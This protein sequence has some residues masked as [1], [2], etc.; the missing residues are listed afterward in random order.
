MKPQASKVWI[1]KPN[2]GKAPQGT[3]AT[4]SKVAVPKP[5]KNSGSASPAVKSVGKKKPPVVPVPQAPVAAVQ[6]PAG[7]I[8]PQPAA[9][10]VIP[11]Q[12]ITPKKEQWFKPHITTD[13]YNQQVISDKDARFV[14]WYKMIK[15]TLLPQQRIEMWWKLLMRLVQETPIEVTEKRKNIVIDLECNHTIVRNPVTSD[16][17]KA[18]LYRSAAEIV[19]LT[20]SLNKMKKHGLFTFIDYYGSRRITK[21]LQ[22][23]ITR[24]NNLI[25]KLVPLEVAMYRPIV[26]VYDVL[27]FTDEPSLEPKKGDFVW[28]QDV[29]NIPIEQMFTTLRESGINHFIMLRQ[30]FEP[31]IVAGVAFGES[32]FYKEEGK[33]RQKASPTDPEW[34]PHAPDTLLWNSEIWQVPNTPDI[35]VWQRHRTISDCY[36][37]S[38]SITDKPIR[39]DSPPH[40]LSYRK[41]D[42]VVEKKIV[43]KY[44]SEKIR[45]KAQDWL[46][47]Y[48]V[49]GV[50][51]KELWVSTRVLENLEERMVGKTRALHQVSALTELVVQEM[52]CEEYN[53]LFS[54]IT[55]IKKSR[56]VNDTVT[57]ITWSNFA[58][59]FSSQK[60]VSVSFSSWMPEFKLVKDVSN[61]IVEDNLKPMLEFSVKA[62]LT[63]FL[64]LLTWYASSGFFKVFQYLRRTKVHPTAKATIF[65]PLIR[66]QVSPFTWVQYTFAP[67][68]EETSKYMLSVMAPTIG[69]IEGF[70]TM[71]CEEHFALR[72][73]PEFN[74]VPYRFAL[75]ILTHV[76]FHQITKQSFPLGVFCHAFWNTKILA[77]TTQDKLEYLAINMI[78]AA[79]A[80][81]FLTKQEDNSCQPYTLFL[82]STLIGCFCATMKL[83]EI[84]EQ[85]K[86]MVDSM[87]R[88]VQEGALP[89]ELARRGI[90][91]VDLTTPKKA[92]V[93][94]WCYALLLLLFTY[95]V[96]ETG[97]W[98]KKLLELKNYIM[99]DSDEGEIHP[100]DLAEAYVP[101]FLAIEKAQEL[102]IADS[103]YENKT[104]QGMYLMIQP[105]LVFQRFQGIYQFL[106][107]YRSRNLCVIEPLEECEFFANPCKLNFEWKPSQLYLDCPLANRWH[108]LRNI[109][110]NFLKGAEFDR[111]DWNP[112]ILT[113]EQWIEKFGSAMKKARAREGTEKVADGS[114]Y[115]KSNIFL[116]SDEVHYPKPDFKGRTIKAIDPTIQA[117]LAVQID[118]AFNL[119]KYVLSRKYYYKHHFRFSFSIGSGMTPSG[120]DQ[121]FAESYETVSLRDNSAAFIFAGDDTFFICKIKGKI[122]YG[123]ID[124]SKYDRTQGAHA[125]SFEYHILVLLGIRKKDMQLALKANVAT[126][127][128]EEKSLGIKIKCPMPIQRATGGPDTTLGNSVN[129]MASVIHAAQDENFHPCMLPEKQLELGFVSKFN[130]S[131]SPR[132]ITFL[133]GWFVPCDQSEYLYAWLPLPS[134]VLKIGK[135]LTNPTDIFPHLS[136]CKA[137][138]AAGYGVA[139]GVG[140]IP[141]NYPILGPIVHKYITIAQETLNIAEIDVFLINNMRFF[142][143][144]H[145]MKIENLIS[146]NLEETLL[147]Y[148]D[149]YNIN[150]H[151]IEEVHRLIDKIT[152]DLFP[153]MVEHPVWNK[154]AYDYR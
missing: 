37:I 59:E 110:T 124:F 10:P 117:L 22:S 63:L 32:P 137:R 130:M 96:S 3:P 7:P 51:N 23:L 12:P 39:M 11:P 77:D 151:E 19:G 6:A 147:M 80:G 113:Q 123:E 139:R 57:Y 145:K 4:G 38:G 125:L 131:I 119:L 14:I 33:I 120:L 95:K 150:I 52:D 40:Q 141:P 107:A 143:D 41:C 82:L 47:D 16:H 83:F 5:N 104:K 81:L 126:A 132:N 118:S 64:G 89:D 115:L 111:T 100:I 154:L 60:D 70:Q 127:V 28:I 112:A 109:V 27:H 2:K 26:T 54:S 55:A 49:Q 62:L 71:A 9:A 21:L 94:S 42:L 134:Q 24:T 35:V 18:R 50:Y 72:S 29:Y 1:T 25:G 93:G 46:G 136:P 66:R 149:R 36:V 90:I 45:A 142:K 140:A 73:T 61:K 133:K 30:L 129:N 116:K 103:L 122:S 152:P 87:K 58:Q 15:K 144:D 48:F 44:L 106:H 76:T 146:I 69:I 31:Q 78:P 135:I 85:S 84:S 153:C 56:V 75:K 65:G 99:G 105:S 79:F 138:I 91:L 88:L 17:H 68:I 8:V 20:L 101:P 74:Y 67:L 97:Y 108:N 13:V 148:L 86:Q 98:E 128:Y 121:W 102:E 34:Y 92:T 43:P 53:L 114:I